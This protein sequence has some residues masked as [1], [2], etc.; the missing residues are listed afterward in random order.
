VLRLHLLLRLLC[1]LRR[2]PRRPQQVL[3]GQ[4][5][6]GPAAGYWHVSSVDVMPDPE[7]S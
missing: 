4:R 3:V 6:A 1:G 7:L 5:R 2:L